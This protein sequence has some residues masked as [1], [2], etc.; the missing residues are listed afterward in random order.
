MFPSASHLQ[1]P[2]PKMKRAVNAVSV[3]STFCA[4][5]AAWFLWAGPARSEQI[6][7]GFTATV[8]YIDNFCWCV[9]DVIAIGDTVLGYYVYESPAI[10]TNPDPRIGHYLYSTSP[11]RIVVYLEGYK[12]ETNA[13]NVNIEFTVRDSV[14]T[15]FGPRDDYRFTSWN[16]TTTIPDN[17]TTRLSVYFSDSTSQAVDDDSLPLSPPDLEVW[18]Y[19]HAVGMLGA[20]WGIY[21]N[22]ISTQWG[23]PTAVQPSTPGLALVRNEPNP[24]SGSTVVHWQSTDGP[25]TLRVFDV[26]GRLVRTLV[27][28]SPITSSS[29]SIRWAGTDASGRPVASGIYFLQ[30]ST[31]SATVTRKM[32]LLR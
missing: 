24:F 14:D 8:F 18:S 10:D 19:G 2:R 29:N 30:M 23:S 22:I 9:P 20:V 7:V 32:V 5:I 12:F 27:D 17:P 3:A 4:F 13:S 6:T 28:R 21:A 1:F 11:N 15:G 25:V 31:P 16:N 26:A